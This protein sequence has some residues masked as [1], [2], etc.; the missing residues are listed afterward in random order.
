M[1][2]LP[3][4]TFYMAHRVALL[5]LSIAFLL[6]ILEMVRRGHLKER[7]ALFWMASALFGMVFGL[8]PRII[9]W[10][11]GLL[12]FQYL[13]V[14]FVLSVLYL[15]A[16]VLAFTVILS[17]LSEKTRGL[18]QEAALLAERIARLEEQKREP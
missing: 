18:A 1:E 8:F 13:T 17:Q 16:M 7:Y 4:L 9:V 10:M 5:L 11:A 14:A 2:T 6:L 3:E 15:M 12:G